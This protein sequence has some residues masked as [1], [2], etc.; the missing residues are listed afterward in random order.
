LTWFLLIINSANVLDNWAASPILILTYKIIILI[1]IESRFSYLFI[2]FFTWLYWLWVNLIICMKVWSKRKSILMLFNIEW[3]SEILK[4]NPVFALFDIW[5]IFKKIIFLNNIFLIDIIRKLLSSLI[6]HNN[7]P[8]LKIDMIL[9][10]C[11]LH[12]KFS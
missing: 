10:F 2:T 9:L 8:I 4:F 5:L 3:I 7:F 1:Y 12:Y 6:K 11:C